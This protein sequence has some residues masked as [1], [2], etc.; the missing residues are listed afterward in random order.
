MDDIKF[1]HI[2]YIHHPNILDGNLIY[3]G[4]ESDI[5]NIHLKIGTIYTLRSYL[6]SESELEKRIHISCIKIVQKDISYPDNLSYTK[7]LT[8]NPENFGTLTDLR[9]KQI[10]IIINGKQNNWVHGS[11]QKIWY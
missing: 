5:N 11:Y 10:N 8:I 1:P 9:D 4:G 3:L 7:I 6:Y 2:R